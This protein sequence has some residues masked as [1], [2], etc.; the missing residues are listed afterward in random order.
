M[1][2]GTILIAFQDETGLISEYDTHDLALN[3]V[4]RA[5]HAR[6]LDRPNHASTLQ[7]NDNLQFKLSGRS[8]YV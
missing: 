5:W 2:S 4:T 6:K 3:N 7:T 8:Y 1:A